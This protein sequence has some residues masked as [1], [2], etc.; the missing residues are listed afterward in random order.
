MTEKT[1]KPYDFLFSVAPMMDWT[2]RS[3]K[4]KQHQHLSRTSIDHVVPNVVLPLAL[5]ST[6]KVC[7]AAASVL[8]LKRSAA[9][10]CAVAGDMRLC[11]RAQDRGLRR[12]RSEGPARIQTSYPS[13]VV[14]IAGIA[15]GC[16][17]FTST[18]ASWRRSRFA[19]ATWGAD[20][21]GRRAEMS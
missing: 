21:W 5:S 6:S 7:R 18:F 19:C 10:R 3:R 15:F 13:F 2:G 17:P 4:A 14:R 9:Y 12:R 1:T 8:R 16:T 20:I 11:R